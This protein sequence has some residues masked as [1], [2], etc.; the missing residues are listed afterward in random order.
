MKTKI[1]IATVLF[2]IHANWVSVAF[3]ENPKI[4][5]Q[6]IRKELHVGAI[7]LPPYYK[8]CENNKLIPPDVLSAIVRAHEELYNQ[9]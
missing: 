6:Q 4:E 3:S 1:F 7:N 2:L 5:N 9:P 8:Y